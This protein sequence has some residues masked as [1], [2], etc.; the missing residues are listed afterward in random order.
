MKNEGDQNSEL[1]QRLEFRGSDVPCVN[2]PVISRGRFSDFLLRFFNS[3]W[4]R[5]P[6]PQPGQKGTLLLVWLQ[7]SALHL[8]KAFEGTDGKMW[9]VR[10]PGRLLRVYSVLS[11]EKSTPDTCSQFSK[12][13]HSASAKWTHHRLKILEKV[14]NCVLQNHPGL[15]WYSLDGTV[16]ATVCTASKLQ[17]YC[18]SSRDDWQEDVCR[19]Y[20]NTMPFHTWN[21]NSTDFGVC[22]ESGTNNNTV[23]M[24]RLSG[25]EFRLV[26][27]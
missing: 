7:E 24:Q 9:S 19:P 15:F 1:S 20:T 16:W 26:G 12:T 11:G 3:L 2:M 14:S 18:N 6:Q 27:V 8:Q 25:F 13:A 23:H 17:Y 10:G 22:E 4:R 21:W 5:G